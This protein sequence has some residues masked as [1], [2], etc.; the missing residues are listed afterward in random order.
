MNALYDYYSHQFNNAGSPSKVQTTVQS[1]Q[2]PLH[3][4]Y[5]L[6]DV[7]SFFKKILNGLPGGLLGSTELFEAIHAVFKSEPASDFSHHNVKSL[8]AK[9][10]ALAILSVPSLHRF[11]L[12]Q[13][14]LG[15]AAYLGNEAEL[16]RVAFQP[17]REKELDRKPSSELMGFQALG[18]CL[19]PLLMGDLT[20]KIGS[21][22]GMPEDTPRTSTESNQKTKK[23]R[24]SIVPNK[25]ERDADLNAHVERA[26]LT[27]NTMQ[28][29]L[30][31]WQEV[32]NQLSIVTTPNKTALKVN[33]TN[34]LRDM[35]R[36]LSN[37]HSV[38][39]SDEEL[40]FLDMMRGGRLPQD[41]PLDLVIKRKVKA[42]N[43]S[44]IS[45]LNLKPSEQSPQ[46]IK[47]PEEPN[48]P[49]AARDLQTPRQEKRKAMI[50][51]QTRTPSDTMPSDDNRP[52]GQTS[53][54]SLEH[55]NGVP[56]LDK[57]SM[58]QILPARD[59]SRHPSSKSSHLRRH[60]T[61]RTPRQSDSR[62]SSVAATETALKDLSSSDR[63]MI[64]DY[65]SQVQS[66]DKPL[67]AL[68]RESSGVLMS[69]LSLQEQT[70][71]PRQSSLA[72]DD[73]SS[74]KS[75]ITPKPT[76]GNNGS[77]RARTGSHSTELASIDQF[78]GK[79]TDGRQNQDDL[80]NAEPSQADDANRIS[81]RH[82]VGDPSLTGR[83]LELGSAQ[84]IVNRSEHEL[85]LIHA[86]IKPLTSPPS[87]LDDP[88][89]S[90]RNQGSPK[91]SLIP[92]PVNGLGH[93]RLAS[94][95]SISPPKSLRSPKKSP[96]ASNI[97]E[98]DPIAM[99]NHGLVTSQAPDLEI[100]KDESVG[101]DKKTASTRPLSAYTFESLQRLK[102][103]LE[104]P[105]TAL[106]IPTRIL[107]PERN[108]TH[109]TSP[110]RS[111]CNPSSSESPE[112]T[113]KRSGSANATLYAEITRLKRQLEQRTEEVLATRRS[114][115]AARDTREQVSGNSTPK[116][117]SWNKGTLSAEIREMRRDRDV[118]KKRAEWAE[119]RLEGLGSLAHIVADGRHGES[120]EESA[121]DNSDSEAE[122]CT[123]N[124]RVTQRK[125]PSKA[126]VEDHKNS[127]RSEDSAQVIV[128]LRTAF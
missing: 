69:D 91:S 84:S 98:D 71:P 107:P 40:L 20:D 60:T 21:P 13:A 38:K 35:S 26:N 76:S 2:L 82:G 56:G 106:H 119:K 22:D 54:S 89:S 122:A 90:L 37:A 1:G 27:A 5:A 29:L 52:P 124:R 120:F 73:N 86:F 99:Q 7:A 79:S 100:G 57:M 31:I 24:L 12:I 41:Q 110:S 43:K 51:F 128:D 4:E 113:V 32:V 36:R 50:D 117:G 111:N 118:W 46:G 125:A 49:D 96:I 39:V 80:D 75:H 6:P 42:K 92:K 77:N 101:R 58:G 66:L 34:Q 28:N 97:F 65:D 18:V 83:N 127:H 23:K 85:P 68:K 102:L 63:N 10:I 55:L 78:H 15:L 104:E 95:R 105:Q 123:N 81:D 8:R 45:R 109:S 62:R 25:L 72:S 114:L 70:Y 11:H 48:Q 112:T 9:L 44:S 64:R 93:G 87:S 115:D 33:S 103:A 121:W 61:M 16:A 47:R 17:T 126:S 53:S 116:R 14:V 74:T 59:S 108:C 88:F 30:T 94:S 19:G 67:P 3:I